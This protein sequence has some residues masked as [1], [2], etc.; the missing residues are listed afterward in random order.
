MLLRLQEP[1]TPYTACKPL[2]RP[3]TTCSTAPY[4]LRGSIQHSAFERIRPT[5]GK[6]IRL[7]SRLQSSPL[8]CN[9]PIRKPVSTNPTQSCI[10]PS[11]CSAQVRRSTCLSDLI[12]GKTAAASVRRT[13]KTNAPFQHT[14][15][16]PG[17][18]L[19]LS[20]AHSASLSTT[21]E[22]ILLMFVSITS[23]LSLHVENLNPT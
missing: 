15:Q 21:T 19:C 9:I 6:A 13:G 14:A 17:I 8:R 22:T 3:I 10:L 16:A 7:S 18:P 11:G 4:P 20:L 5:K 23:S 12:G 1:R 2:P